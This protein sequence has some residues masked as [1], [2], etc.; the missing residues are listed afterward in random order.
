[1]DL[2]QTLL[3]DLKE[4]MKARN[5]L[6]V[7]TLRILNSE[8][9][10]REI[11]TK[12]DLDDETILALVTTQIKRRR[13]AAIQYEKGGRPELKEKEEKEID[14]LSAY[15]PK[16]ATEEELRERISQ[17]IQETGAAGMKDMG[18]VM[19]TVVAEFKGKADGGR[20]KELVQ[21]SLAG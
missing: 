18:K 12:Q 4:A 2:K 11:D 1:M 8:I 16:Q 13:E 9:K 3:S 19:K 5:S 6:K 20:L 15:L 17:V 14:I 10:N 7:D 21:E